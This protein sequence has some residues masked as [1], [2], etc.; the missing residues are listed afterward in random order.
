MSHENK[1]LRNL[2]LK[3]DRDLY[4]RCPRCAFKFDEYEGEF[5][6]WFLL[7]VFHRLVDPVLF[8]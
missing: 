8:S 6:C 1:F 2:Y 4:L 5:F 3:V 7:L